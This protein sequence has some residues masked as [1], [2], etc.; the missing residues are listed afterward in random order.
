V[1]LYRGLIILALLAAVA[2]FAINTAWVRVAI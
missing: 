2:M 1:T